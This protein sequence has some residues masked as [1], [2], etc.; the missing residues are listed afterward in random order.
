LSL[1]KLAGQTVIY[2]ISHILPRIISFILLTPYLTYK[3]PNQEDYGIF[4]NLYTYSTIII[5]LMVFRMDTTYFRFAKKENERDI[6]TQTFL[7]L[8]IISTTIVALLLYNNAYIATLL[9]YPG[10]GYYVSWFAL[11]L[12]FD[13]YTSLIYARFRL[14]QRP[15]KFMLFKF[16]NV[17]FICF[18]T[19]YFLEFLP[20]YY[21]D[22]KLDI[23]VFFEVKSDIDYVFLANL[24]ASFFVFL[25]LIPELLKINFRL[26]KREYISILKYAWPL[27]IIIVAGTV[28]QYGPA[29]FQNYFLEGSKVEKDKLIGIFGGSAKIAILL[30]LFTTAFN[31]AAEPFFFNQAKTDNK[32]SMN[33]VVSKAFTIVCCLAI[34]G[35]Y[36]FL[37]ITFIII[38]K[39][40]RQEDIV[41]IL[42]MSY[43][44]L[45]LYYNISIWYKLADKTIYGA[46]IAVAAA[47]ITLLVSAFLI[48]VIGTIGSAWAA[49]ICF[50]FELALGYYWGQKYFPIQYPVK[51]ILGYVGLT[52][53]LLIVIYMIRHSV[54]QVILRNVLCT[55]PLM[56]FLGY[57]WK[58][59]KVFLQQLKRGKA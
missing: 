56:V 37:D 36:G 51:N 14:Q 58:V 19:L 39:T 10:Q 41:P 38:G 15:M 3:F 31:Y 27:A 54:D 48:P 40:Y 59:D 47:I 1:K 22:I 44:F 2:G 18:F 6:Y 5:A 32:H 12:A 26:A 4:T 8:A 21:P 7:I 28:N 35:L 23:D 55:I 16:L 11:I 20:K 13:A 24:L 53:L 49:L 57:L 42:L 34:L 17:I 33:G 30:N 25:L 45:G 50:A 46:Y 52:S 9:Q 29:M 43:L